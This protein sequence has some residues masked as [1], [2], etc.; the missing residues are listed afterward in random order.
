M[1]SCNLLENSLPATVGALASSIAGE[2]CDEDLNILAAVM[3]LLGDSLAT[4]AALRDKCSAG[5]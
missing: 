4:I 5:N 1:A 2:L 3:T